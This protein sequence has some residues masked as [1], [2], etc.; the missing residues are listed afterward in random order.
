[1]NITTILSRLPTEVFTCA[2]YAKRDINILT[3]RRSPD[4]KNIAMKNCP[5]ARIAELELERE[6]EVSLR[7]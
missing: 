3:A 1:M 2:I 7:G 6:I 5:A 4:N